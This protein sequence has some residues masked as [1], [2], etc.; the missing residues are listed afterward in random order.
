MLDYLKMPLGRGSV[1][2]MPTRQ[3]FLWC[4]VLSMPVPAVT[5]AVS[6]LM[7]A[8]YLVKAEGPQSG[9]SAKYLLLKLQTH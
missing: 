7:L 9:L 2:E 6:A 1:C 5:L 3:H 4:T 8:L